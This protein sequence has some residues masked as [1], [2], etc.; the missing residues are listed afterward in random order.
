MNDI[1]VGPRANE[2]DVPN[3]DVLTSVGWGR[4]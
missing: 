3:V 4:C 2:F 1:M